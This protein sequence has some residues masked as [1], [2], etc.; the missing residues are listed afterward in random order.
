MS[1]SNVYIIL[2]SDSGAREETLQPGSHQIITLISLMLVIQN[3]HPKMDYGHINKIT[4][5]F[6]VLSD[7][8]YQCQQWVQFIRARTKPFLFLKG[9]SFG[10][11]VHVTA[12]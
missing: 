10:L 9:M 4:W 5:K 1:P 7:E 11:I 6:K 2:K 8:L 3:D 12:L